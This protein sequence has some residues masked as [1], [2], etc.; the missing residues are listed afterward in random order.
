M[1]DNQETIVMAAPMLNYQCNLK[2]CCCKG[3]GIPF[4]P[5]GVA[6]LAGAMPADE[7]KERLNWGMEFFVNDK[8]EIERI[9][10]ARLP[11]DDRCRFLE[12]E[13]QCEIH[14]R[15]GTDALPDLCIN[16]PAV[17][18]HTGQTIELHYEAVCPSVLD[19]LADPTVPYMPT[20]LSAQEHPEIAIRARRPNKRPVMHLGQA[21]LQWPQMET[22]RNTVLT[23]LQDLQRPAIE[24]LCAISYAFGRLR[25]HG[26]PQRFE[27]RYDEPPE[28]FYDFLNTCA[29]A[30]SGLA[31][32]QLWPAFKRFVWDFDRDDPKLEHLEHWLD[33]W[34]EPLERW[35][36]GQEPALRPLLVRFLAHRYFSAFVEVR[37]EL[38]FAYGSIPHAHALALRV[39][40]A[41]SGALERPTD[42]GIMKAALGFADY[43]YRG[44]KIP[45]SSLP[46]FEPPEAD[47]GA[48]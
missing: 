28:P 25:Q 3:W 12:P 4:K 35:M 41:L 5:E 22:L 17:P 36:I 30:H 38:I 2:G 23:S 45:V 15:F 42:V 21:Q 19:Q 1:S 6:R 40:A 8:Q 33:H 31:L 9:E 18:Y 29:H 44:L 37:G 34:E 14:R 27:I 43:I 13:G 47:T 16:F 32:I 26:D 7:A 46:W 11:P 48:Q 20:A 10:L 24:H 39:A